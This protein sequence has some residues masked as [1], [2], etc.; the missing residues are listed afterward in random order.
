MDELLSIL[1]LLES[2]EDRVFLS[3]LSASLL[4][5]PMS[6]LPSFHGIALSLSYT[7]A[8]DTA[9]AL[10]EAVLPPSSETSSPAILF[11]CL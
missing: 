3:L 2:S 11:R 7:F 5:F 6:V 10:A 8:A 1:P 4:G 9:Y